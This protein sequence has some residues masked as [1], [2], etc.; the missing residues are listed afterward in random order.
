MERKS[1]HP[2][3]CGQVRYR[4]LY[5][6]TNVRS[7]DGEAIDLTV[8]VFVEKCCEG[9]LFEQRPGRKLVTIA[10]FHGAIFEV[11]ADNMIRKDFRI[12]VAAM[13]L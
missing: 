10:G 13:K 9:A 2:E 6:I 8:L 11:E 4:F 1:T 7:D 5:P 3:F 12:D